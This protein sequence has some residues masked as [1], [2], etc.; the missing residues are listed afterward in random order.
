MSVITLNTN[1][2]DRSTLLSDT[3]SISI[4][5]MGNEVSTYHIGFRHCLVR[6][7]ELDNTLSLSSS[8]VL[9]ITDKTGQVL[10]IDNL[11]DYS[12]FDLPGWVLMRTTTNTADPNVTGDY[13]YH[14]H[15]VV[16]RVVKTVTF[17]DGINM[18]D[19][20]VGNVVVLYN[21]FL[22]Y[23]LFDG[24]TQEP[25]VSSV[26]SVP[27]W[28]TFQTYPG[29]MF[30]HSDGR[31]IMMFN[32]YETGTGPSYIGYVY[33]TDLINWTIGNEDNYVY[34]PSVSI[35]DC[36]Y[37]ALQGS[38]DRLDD[39]RYYCCIGITK[40]SGAYGE[41]RFLYFDEDLT[42]FTYSDPI[43][44]SPGFAYGCSNPVFY[45]EL[46]H[47]PVFYVHPSD[48]SLRE[49]REYVCETRTGVYTLNQNIIKAA[50]ATD[51]MTCSYS[52]GQ[53]VFFNYHD[54]IFGLF[55]GTS[56]WSGS[57]TKGNRE[58]SL[59]EFDKTTEVWSVSDKGVVI[60]N[61][62]YYYNMDNTYEWG[63]DHGGP[64]ICLGLVD[65][66][67]FM[68]TCFKGVNSYAYELALGALNITPDRYYIL[69]E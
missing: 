5:D 41:S 3:E 53:V 25:I 54:N 28:R 49:I 36:K 10:T 4:T 8:T 69:N 17:A 63:T 56:K 26:G 30:K 64:N 48:V 18:S 21:S 42:T 9:T 38:I 60:L 67:I 43:L 7:T 13:L 35:P 45:N 37:T 40:T 68:T 39:G 50:D 20:S 14:N 29:P 58:F 1:P 33:S 52:V 55:D 61:P 34:A 16:D 2:F 46:Y 66:K 59:L 22:N 6:N 23:S 11:P 12:A 44:G 31:Y 32:A 15:C 24:Q 19:W 51:G 47:L 57:G 65:D 27:T 62:M